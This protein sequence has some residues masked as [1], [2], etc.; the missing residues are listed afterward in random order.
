MDEGNMGDTLDTILKSRR[1]PEPSVDLAAH[2]IADAAR[3]P[4]QH[5]AGASKAGGGPG[6]FEGVRSWWA[7]FA[8]GFALPQPALVMALVLFIGV[9]AGAGGMSEGTISSDESDA[10]FGVVV[11]DVMDMEG[12]S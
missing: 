3:H 2:I 7:D 5:A 11:L 8:D 6:L 9:A 1:V 10:P 4:Q 12:L